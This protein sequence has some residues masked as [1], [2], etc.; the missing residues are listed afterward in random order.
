[1]LQHCKYNYSLDWV[2]FN[3]KKHQWSQ[4]ACGSLRTRA[5][6]ANLFTEIQSFPNCLKFLL[7]SP[8]SVQTSKR[9][10][11][12][13]IK[14]CF[15]KQIRPIAVDCHLGYVKRVPSE[16]FGL[17]K[18]HNL[19]VHCPTRE[20]TRCNVVVQVPGRIVW[21]ISFQALCNVRRQ[22]AYALVSL[23]NRANQNS[24]QRTFTSNCYCWSNTIQIFRILD[25]TET[26]HLPIII[27]QFWCWRRKFIYAKKSVR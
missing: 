19:N 25:E 13:Y 14:K 20:V 17:L 15:S 6:G 26:R 23:W 22:V 7:L 18:G 10:A 3:K 5:P 4:L 11:K 9:P 8:K 21:I 1:M 27:R 24:T 16:T 2:L 12:S